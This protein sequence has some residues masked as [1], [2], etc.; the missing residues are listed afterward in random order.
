MPLPIPPAPPTGPRSGLLSVTRL[1]PLKGVD[2]AIRLA[3]ALGEPLTV[4]GDGPEKEALPDGPHVT[5]VGRKS[6][7]ELATLYARAKGVVLLPRTTEDGM[8]AEGL[9]L[10]LLEAAAQGAVPI[11]CRVGGVAEAVGPGIV[12]DDPDRYDVAAIR[13]VLDDP[14]LP[15]KCHAFV[16]STHG[17]E[18]TLQVLTRP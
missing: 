10:C 14:S 3:A 4:V 8:G 16:E 2:R 7:D 5:W 18:R 11:G 9:G 17:P 6:R 13:R 12:L 15:A 1:T